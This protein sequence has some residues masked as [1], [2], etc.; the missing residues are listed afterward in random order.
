MKFKNYIKNFSKYSFYIDLKDLNYKSHYLI[1]GSQNKKHLNKILN[2]NKKKFFLDIS[3]KKINLAFFLNFLYWNSFFKILINENFTTAYYDIIIRNLEC[4]SV[5]TFYD[6][7]INF[8]KLKNNLRN[9]KF[10]SIQ[11]GARHMFNDIFGLDELKYHKNLKADYIFVFNDDIKKL[12]EKYIDAKVIVIGSFKNNIIRKLN[13]NKKNKKLA[14]ISQYRESIAQNKQLLYWKKKKISSSE[15]YKNDYI[16]IKTIS[17]FCQNNKIKFYVICATNDLSEKNYFKTLVDKK[18]IYFIEKKK[19]DLKVYNSIHAFDLLV[20]SWSTLGYESL[21]RDIKTC[22]FRQKIKNLPDRS[23]GWPNKNLSKSTFFYTENVNK[24]KINKIL[25][26]INGMS[27]KEWINK[28][29]NYKNKVM[30][31]DYQNKILRKFLK[32]V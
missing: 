8:Y 3:K 26:Q 19:N 11:N 1:I 21:S 14:Y 7:N 5:I 31:F 18:K 22:F 12:Y 16:L 6:N 28:T 9:V 24:F 29:E 10:I 23:F 17:Q 2:K 32:N 20:C 30:Y 13:I 27:H 4:R 25:N 15:F